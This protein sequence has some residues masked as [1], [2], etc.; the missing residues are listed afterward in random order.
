[1]MSGSWRSTRLKA[2]AKETP[3]SDG[4]RY[5]VAV[6]FGRENGQQLPGASDGGT[7]LS[8]QEDWAESVA[9]PEEAREFFGETR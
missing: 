2:R 9:N 5:G 1:M 6:W 4:R 7:G 3:D 8:Y